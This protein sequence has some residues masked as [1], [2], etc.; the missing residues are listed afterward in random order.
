MFKVNNV[1]NK[2]GNHLSGIISI[3]AKTNEQ[4][5]GGFKPVDN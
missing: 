5:H 4:E 2:T 3:Q 1:T